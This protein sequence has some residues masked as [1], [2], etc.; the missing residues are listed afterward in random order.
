MPTIEVLKEG[1]AGVATVVDEGALTRSRPMVFEFDMVPASTRNEH[2]GRVAVWASRAEGVVHFEV[3]GETFVVFE[4][5][6]RAVRRILPTRTMPFVHWALH[7]MPGTRSRQWTVSIGSELLL[8]SMTVDQ[9][10]HVAGALHAAAE[11]VYFIIRAARHHANVNWHR[12]RERDD[13][14]FD[15]R[16][17]ID[18]LVGLTPV[19]AFVDRLAAEHIVARR[20]RAA[21]LEVAPSSP[22]LVFTGNPGTGKTTVARLIG[23]LYAAL[24]LLE[25]GH[26]VEAERST[27]VGSYLGQTAARTTDVCESALGGVLFVDE[28]YSL[29][30]EGRDYG[31]EAIETILTFMENNRGRVV[32]I[33]AGYPEEMEH[34]LDSNPGLRSRF[35]ATVHF[36][37][38]STEDL[39]EVIGN[40]FDEFDYSLSAAAQTKLREYV[41]SL[42][43][44]RGFG[45]AR[46]MHKL[47]RQLVGTHATWLCAAGDDEPTEDA[48]LSWIEAHMIPDPIS[49]PPPP[50]PAP[51]TPLNL[52]YL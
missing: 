45:N 44:G 1:F 20:R 37:D 36:P 15:V 50:P 38:H 46:E 40:L 4:R 35:D 27:L 18:E 7:Q 5:E 51:R 42:P 33:M 10:R 52:G 19:K 14:L 13:A 32:V 16:W 8:T 43:R 47:F 24:G 31:R 28:A 48:D 30:V 22:H 17:E 6:L 34:L 49:A 3:R 11:R 2:E 12:Q 29:D 41:A 9:V 25:K 39:L 23:R 26:V 21:D